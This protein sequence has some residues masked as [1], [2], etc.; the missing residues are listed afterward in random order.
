MENMFKQ[1]RLVFFEGE[2][3]RA[4]E[5]VEIEAELVD[6]SVDLNMIAV[7]LEPQGMLASETPELIKFG[8]ELDARLKE[9]ARHIDAEKY[10][11][12]MQSDYDKDY[13]NLVKEG[14][15]LLT[16]YYSAKS[17]D[18]EM[19]LAEIV[20][21]DWR[22]ADFVKEAGNIYTRADLIEALDQASHYCFEMS[23]RL[24]DNL[25]FAKRIL[26]KDEDAQRVAIEDV[27]RELMALAE[28]AIIMRQ[29]QEFDLAKKDYLINRV[30]EMA[31]GEGLDENQ[32][33]VLAY[34]IY[35]MFEANLAF[36]HEKH[37]DKSKF[38]GLFDEAYNSVNM[39]LVA[40][41]ITA[42]KKSDETKGDDALLKE[43]LDYMVFGLIDGYGITTENSGKFSDDLIDLTDGIAEGS[44]SDENDLR[45]KIETILIMHNKEVP[46]LKRD[47]IMDTEIREGEY[48][49][50]VAK[51][52]DDIDLFVEV[53]LDDLTPLEKRFFRGA[54][55]MLEPGD[56]YEF[57]QS[58]DRDETGIKHIY[59]MKDEEGRVKLMKPADETEESPY[60]LAVQKK[61]VD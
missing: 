32:Q 39:D 30:G 23:G 13:D 38:K 44:I 20:K 45:K 40:E 16:L 56:K 18:P 61:K 2:V 51:F 10:L 57:K 8:Q 15:E 35:G 14:D 54:E 4:R 27:Q 31:L 24:E 29:E 7:A 28:E 59:V 17:T 1:N 22:L 41:R 34:Y 9:K 37:F 48:L 42:L 58:Y 53:S 26:E 55:A 33:V 6:Q 60:R 50:E 49:W 12:A 47:E 5:A 11:D 36:D 46:R 19:D 43:K 25:R 21:S 3:P 52:P